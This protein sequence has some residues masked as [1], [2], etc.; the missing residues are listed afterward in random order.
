MRPSKQPDALRART[1]WRFRVVPLA[2]IGPIRPRSR[3]IIRSNKH[4]VASHRQH[5][6]RLHPRLVLIQGL[7][8]LCIIDC[9][10][11]NVQRGSF[12]DDSISQ[13]CPKLQVSAKNIVCMSRRSTFSLANDRP[14]K[15][16]CKPRSE[17]TGSVQEVLRGCVCMYSNNFSIW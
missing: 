9:F 2:P 16:S 13:S 4:M 11:S 15:A 5:S 6:S 3:T 8:L 17:R 1:R 7:S 10:E 14:R 12:L